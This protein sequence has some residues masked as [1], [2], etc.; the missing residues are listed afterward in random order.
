MG[1]S[2]EGDDSILQRFDELCL[3]LNMDK[4]SK[5]EALQSYHR[6]RTNFTLE[7]SFL[8]RETAMFVL[9]SRFYQYYIR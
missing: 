7:V 4:N 1:L 6:T 8:N 2:E 5:D 9:N 3:D